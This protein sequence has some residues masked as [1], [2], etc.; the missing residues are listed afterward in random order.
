M[1]DHN[2]NRILAANFRKVGDEVDR[3]LFEG[4][5]GRRGD[6]VQRRFGRMGVYFVLLTG[7]TSFDESID[8]CG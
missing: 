8:I 1:V 5:S 4:E 6:R 3:D 7:G 2:Q